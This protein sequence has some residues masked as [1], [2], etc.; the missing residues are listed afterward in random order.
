VSSSYEKD[1]ILWENKINFL[2]QQREQSKT[3]NADKIRKLEST[4]DNLQRYRQNEKSSSESQHNEYVSK[5]EKKYLSQIS[6][7]NENNTKKM[8]EYEA[9]IKDH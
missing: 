1:R 9:S 8:M 5:I 3:E 6:E 2:E 7:L 4:I